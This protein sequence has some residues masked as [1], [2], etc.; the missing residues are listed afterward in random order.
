MKV[1]VKSDRVPIVLMII[2]AAFMIA[3][4]LSTVIRNQDILFPMGCIIVILG[5][6]LWLIPTIQK[7]LRKKN[8]VRAKIQKNMEDD[9]R[10]RRYARRR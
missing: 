8:R 1:M 9:D 7:Y 2:G 6:L 10:P 3:A 5:F 4:S